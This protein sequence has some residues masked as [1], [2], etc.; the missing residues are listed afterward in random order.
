MQPAFV[1][2]KININKWSWHYQISNSQKVQRPETLNSYGKFTLDISEA[3]SDA[4]MQPY[5]T[6]VSTH[7]SIRDA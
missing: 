4:R 5:L 1:T 7:A 3:I 6:S 2:Q